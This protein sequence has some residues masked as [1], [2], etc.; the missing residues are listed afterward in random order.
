MR[1][2]YNGL[3][4]KI[5]GNGTQVFCKWKTWKAEIMNNYVLKYFFNT[6]GNDKLDVIEEDKLRQEVGNVVTGCKIIAWVFALEVFMLGCVCYGKSRSIEHIAEKLLV[7]ELAAHE[8]ESLKNYGD[9]NR[10]VEANDGT[11]IKEN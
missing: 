5:C 7:E 1:V 2:I 4:I 9:G 10:D 11:E 6:C 8:R 3:E